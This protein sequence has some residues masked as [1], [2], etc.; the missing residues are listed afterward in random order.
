MFAAATKKRTLFLSLLLL[1]SAD[2]IYSND[3]WPSAAEWNT[4]NE[5]VGNRL[6]KSGNPFASCAMDSSTPSCVEILKIF[7][8][9]YLIQEQ[10]WGTQSIGWFKAWTTA[11]SPFVVEAQTTDDIVAAVNFARQHRLRLVVK[12]CG[13]D[14][15]GRSCAPD[16]LL[17]WTHKMR[18]ITI[19][20][21]FI[22]KGAP[23][24][25]QSVPAVSAQAGARWIDAYTSVTT[26]HQR[27][28]QGGGC[29]TVG[30][31]GGFLQGGG[32]GSFSKRYGTGAGNLI[33]AEIVIANGH[34]LIVNEYQ[35]PDL[36]W[37]LKGGGGGT[38]GVVTRVTLQT[39]ELPKYFG[40]VDGKIKAT[41]D[42]SYRELI[43][44]FIDFYRENLHNPHWGEQ[45]TLNPDNS[46]DLHFV[47]QGLDKE[48]A[49][50]VW[51]PFINWV[52]ERPAAYALT[53]EA[54]EVPADKWWDFEYR[55]KKGLGKLVHY[56][57]NLY[58][59]AG[60]QDEVG[61]YLY[62]HRT[63]WLPIT[64]FS[65][66]NSKNF[67]TTLFNASRFWPIALHF[68]KGLAGAPNETIERERKTAIN[69]IVLDSAALAIVAA[70]AQDIYPGVSG[71]EPDLKRG[72]ELSSKV[73][74]AAQI[75]FDATPGSGSYSN[76]TDYFEKDWQKSFWGD[77][78]SRLLNI[79]Q[80][81]D[82]TNLF[83]CHHSVGSE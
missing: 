37:A 19:H 58:Y 44:K 9:P 39:H 48:Q 67:A 82:P 74:A 2:S 5:S 70:I 30:V 28:V 29:T 22:P 18:D 71:H 72:L 52:K 4:L 32:F 41:G 51:D 8:N 56:K 23:P 36:F 55:E 1:L 69:P 54:R 38:F 61:V 73:N 50:K 83:R 75:I 49:V 42:Q 76:E 40:G 31:A 3:H 59:S 35:N 80:K 20:D 21:S 63:R 81:Y 7:K 6:I 12:G 24:K 27:Y 16:S 64:L 66:E 53:I 78:Y 26:K 13:H 14:Y 79:K 47:F 65:K 11:A 46:L 25:T 68:N 57:E 15:L 45:A 77:N 33:E 62:S 43:E 17:I 60:N 34:V 10:P